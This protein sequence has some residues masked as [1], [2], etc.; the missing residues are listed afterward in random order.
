MGVPV[1]WQMGVELRPRHLDVFEDGLQ[2]AVGRRAG[3]FLLAS[4]A[5]RCLHIR[6]QVGRG[7]AH[8]F[9][10]FLGQ[11]AHCILLPTGKYQ[12]FMTK[13]VRLKFS[14]C[15]KILIGCFSK[16]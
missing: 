10:N 7:K 15:N 13:I 4:L 16:V 8:Q 5:Q 2:R 6:R 14:A 3:F 1:S 11:I 9:Q 12:T